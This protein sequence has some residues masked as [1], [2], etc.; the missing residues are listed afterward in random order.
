MGE[1][2]SSTPPYRYRELRGRIDDELFDLRKMLRLAKKHQSSEVL[3]TGDREDL[4][5]FVAA[6]ETRIPAEQT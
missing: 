2:S 6:L 3:D 1:V 5:R 4:Q